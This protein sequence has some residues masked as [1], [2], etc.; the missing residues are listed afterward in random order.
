[1]IY[2]SIIFDCDGVLLDSNT[3]KS[4]AFYQSVLPFG[5]KYADEFIQY[6]KNNGGISRYKKFE[7]FLNKTNHVNYFEREKEISSARKKILDY[8]TNWHHEIRAVNGH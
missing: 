5:Q 6:H 3:I 1:M 4:E 7:Y 2:K 8:S